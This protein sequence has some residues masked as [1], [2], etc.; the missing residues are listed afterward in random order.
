MV[1][2]RHITVIGVLLPEPDIKLHRWFAQWAGN[3]SPS[4]G[5]KT[6]TGEEDLD[7]EML[8]HGWEG[9]G[10]NTVVSALVISLY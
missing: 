7:K 3:V 5:D 2:H 4:S 6:K 8:D 1:V 9:P 10:N